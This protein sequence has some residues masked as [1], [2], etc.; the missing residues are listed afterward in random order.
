M[1]QSRLDVA[2]K[3]V[4]WHVY[5]NVQDLASRVSGAI[6]RISQEA[7][8]RNGVFRIVL[9]GGSTPRVVYRQLRWIRSDWKRWHIYFGDE[10]CLPC[11]HE[12]RNDRMAAEARRH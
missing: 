7:I 2:D 9:A 11:G 3:R 8:D 6:A 5:P 10:R 12:D 4:C 1:A